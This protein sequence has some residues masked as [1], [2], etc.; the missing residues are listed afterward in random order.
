MA[1]QTWSDVMIVWMKTNTTNTTDVIIAPSTDAPVILQGTSVEVTIDEDEQS[2]PWSPPTLTA[3]NPIAGTL[4][5][6]LAS[7]PPHGTAVVNGTGTSPTTLDYTPNSNYSGADSFVVQVHNGTSIDTITIRVTITDHPDPPTAVDDAV[8]TPMNSQKVIPVLANDYDIDGDPLTITAIGNTS[9]GTAIHDGT[10]ITYTPSNNMDAVT[11]VFSYT[12]GDGTG[13]TDDGLVSITVG[14]GRTGSFSTNL[15]V[16]LNGTNLTRTFTVYVPESYSG[17]P[18]PLLF[19]FHEMGSSGA[20]AASVAY[21]WITTASNNNFIAIFP[22]SQSGLPP[23]PGTEAL[24]GNDQYWEIPRPYYTGIDTNSHDM[25]FVIA[26]LE[27]A[28]SEYTIRDTHI[29]TTGQTRGGQFSLHVAANLPD[30]IA[31]FGMYSAGGYGGTGWGW[32]AYIPPAGTPPLKAILMWNTGDP[33]IADGQCPGMVSLLHS[34]AHTTVDV[35]TDPGGHVWNTAYNQ[36]QW[37][38]FMSNSPPVDTAP[39]A[40]VTATP[41]LGPAPLTVTFTGSGSTDDNGIVSYS[42]AFGDGGTTNI[43][44]PVYTYAGTG[45]FV[46]VL[47]VEDTIG[48]TDV[49]SITIAPGGANVPP[50]ITNGPFALHSTVVPG[51]ATTVGVGTTDIN[52]DTLGYAWTHLSGPGAAAFATVLP[53]PGEPVVSNLTDRHV[54]FDTAGSHVLRVVVSDGNGGTAT[55]TVPVTVAAPGTRQYTTHIVI[56]GL[57]RKFIVYIPTGYTGLQEIPLLVMSHGLT[58]TA[59]EAASAYYNWQ[60]V[61]DANN[62]M[63]V[64]PDSLDGYPLVVPS[65][66]D[67]GK[68]WDVAPDGSDDSTDIRFF[69]DMLSWM[70]NRYRI[71]DSQVFA[72]GHSYGGFFSYYAD[73]WMPEIKAFGAHSSGLHV[74]NWPTAVP[75]G[76]PHLKGIL[77]HA[78]DDDVVPYATSTNLYTEMTNHGHTAVLLTLPNGLLHG[79]HSTS[80]QMQWDFFMSGLFTSHRSV[81]VAWLAEQNSAWTNDYEAAATNDPD[82]DGFS[83]ADEYWAGTDPQV[84]ASYPSIDTVHDDGAN[85]VLTWRHA[86]VDGAIP[87]IA[88]Q[89]RTNLVVGGWSPVG[90]KVPVD[91]TNLWSEASGQFP[92]FYRIA[93]TNAP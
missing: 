76:T 91:G 27:W 36:T 71:I 59:E 23:T 51:G 65:D 83:T 42:W 61:A 37:D 6:S 77:L 33:W 56:D 22:D 21:D 88:I 70:T 39:T 29:F 45:T 32:P 3:S 47:T 67:S 86:R 68:H 52:G 46:A 30:E 9:Y 28:R 54:T 34:N 11:D 85:V 63:V 64:F 7:P 12:I 8:V 10:N 19:M 38:F 24:P 58:S 72:T 40:V 92:I 15:N 41:K 5:W 18:M 90:Q 16:Q 60:P 44:D 87:P 93:A 84:G 57:L 2:M 78:Q 35:I 81:P 79:Y 73:R 62:F 66:P 31:A 75:A 26:M 48:Q 82:G 20:S 53:G 1:T 13:R 80:N 89:R 25:R 74:G 14:G 17:S 69:R 43:A 50:S 49:D 4:I 55:G